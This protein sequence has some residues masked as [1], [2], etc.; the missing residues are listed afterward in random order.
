M[1]QTKPTNGR[2][3]F[4]KPSLYKRHPNTKGIDDAVAADNI[5]LMWA[6]SKAKLTPEA[7]AVST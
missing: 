6:Q 7:V 3:L 5:K 1:S 2:A 4:S